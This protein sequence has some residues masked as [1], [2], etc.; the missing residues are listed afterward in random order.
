MKNMSSKKYCEKVE[1]IIGK[2]WI[3]I[4][5]V[6]RQ[7]LIVCLAWTKTK[8]IWIGRICSFLC[9]PLIGQLKVSVNTLTIFKTNI[10]T[11]TA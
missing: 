10:I 5:A 11:E 9:N 8:K 1:I 2:K 6:K 4:L 7:C 3:V